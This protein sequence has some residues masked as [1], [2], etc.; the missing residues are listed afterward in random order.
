MLNKKIM[1]LRKTLNT[2]TQINTLDNE[3][4]LRISQELDVLILQYYKQLPKSMKQKQQ[5]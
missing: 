2:Q 3:Q 1:D 4:V 5:I